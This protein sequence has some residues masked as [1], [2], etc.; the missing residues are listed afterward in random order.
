MTVLP[1]RA[2]PAVA[3]ATGTLLFVVLLLPSWPL[4]L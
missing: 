4:L 1:V 2:V 3:T